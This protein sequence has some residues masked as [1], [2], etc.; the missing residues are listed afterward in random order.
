VRTYTLTLTSQQFSV[1]SNVLDHWLFYDIELDP[2]SGVN[3]VY[4]NSADGSFFSSTSGTFVYP[5]T[6]DGYLFYPAGYGVYNVYSSLTAGPLKGP[7]TFVFD[8][9]GLDYTLYGIQ[10]IVYDFG[11]GQSRVVEYPIGSGYIGTSLTNAPNNLKVTHDYYPTG[12]GTTTYYPSISV[13]NGNLVQNIFNIEIILVPASIYELQNVHLL[14]NIQT[15]TSAL[16]TIN[17]FEI[18]SPH[19]IT[20]AR[21][22]SAS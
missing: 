16:E 13:V 2:V 7:Y 10:K 4:P 17:I 20:H 18:E 8:P 6:A 12:Q 14:N 22:L 9:T 19:Y 11:D 15:S 5:F 1:T 3:F 21:V